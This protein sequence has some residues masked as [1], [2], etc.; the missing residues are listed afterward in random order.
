M[1]LLLLSPVLLSFRI[2][3]HLFTLADL[4]PRS[5]P[6]STFS[7]TS[8]RFLPPQ[9]PATLRTSTYSALSPSIAA[10]SP[11]HQI[12]GGRL[13]SR[14]SSACGHFSNT[15]DHILDLSVDIHGA[16]TLEDALRNLVRPNE[17]SGANQYRCQTCVVSLLL[18]LPAF[19]DQLLASIAA[20]TA[21]ST[22]RK[23]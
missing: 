1:R 21:S 5:P 6:L 7:S 15:F 19:A 18:S 11:L 13:L 20:V 22:P 8:L 9:L 3:S 14:I 10:S 17:L 4:S 16:S 12:F 2:S 23:R